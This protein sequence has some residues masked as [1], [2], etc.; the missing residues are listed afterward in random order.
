ML[1][2]ESVL[3][4]QPPTWTGTHSITKSW[5]I[6]TASPS[7]KNNGQI[8]VNRNN[9]FNFEVEETISFILEV[10]DNFGGRDTI[11][12]TVQLQDVN[13]PPV[14][15]T[16]IPP[17]T[18]AE[19]AAVQVALTRYFNDPDRVD[20]GNLRYDVRVEDATIASA[21]VLNG[22]LTINGI[23]AGSTSITVSASDRG[24]FSVSST[25]TVRVNENIPPRIVNPISDQV[26]EPNVPTIIDLNTVFAN[27]NS[28]T[29]ATPQS[30]RSEVAV[31]TLVGANSNRL[32]I[33]GRSA[34]TTTIT[35]TATS[36]SGATITHSF[37]V[38]VNSTPRV[39]APIPNQVVN[40][41]AST[42][43]NLATVFSDPD[44][45]DRL[46]YLR[47]VVDS[48]IVHVSLTG[49]TLRITGLRSGAT[50]VSVVATDNHG[51][52]VT[53][54]FTVRV[55]SAPSVV[56]AIQPA[57]LANPEATHVVEL[58]NVFSDPDPNDV[59][60]YTATSSNAA[61]A[62]V[63]VT[64]NILLVRAVRPGA[65]SIAVTA[66]DSHGESASTTFNFFVNAVPMLSMA[67][68]DILLP[69]P[70]STVQLT[71]TDHFEDA[72][73]EI[74]TFSAVSDDR[75]VVTVS[76][77]GSTLTVQGVMA[78]SATIS[79][80]ATDNHEQT[81]T[82]TFMVH[83]NAI[84]MVSMAIDDVTLANPDAQMDI[85]L[86]MHFSDADMDSLTYMAESSD[87]NTV[88]VSVSGSTLT[89]QG[90]NAGDATVTVTATDTSDASVLDYVRC[91][92]Q[93]CTYGIHGNRRCDSRQS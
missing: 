33:V 55:N 75:S 56:S 86:S 87:T 93:C 6:R 11:N 30:S 70:T 43:I 78:G 28:L 73:R 2:Q 36:E 34:G 74:L 25:F 53:D 76:V 64:G 92:R 79:V 84:P 4:I 23:T 46:T 81:V 22:I 77:S 88:T 40:T 35:L 31:A 67:F 54:S 52:S 51:A 8:Y 3:H 80:S 20:S 42:S 12:I 65:G 15:V 38:T 45:A 85:D 21:S 9:A 32:V 13:E 68:E 39:I 89:V 5:G 44:P 57:T 37:Q 66:T 26:V 41:G 14:K 10:S 69:L 60:T 48:S 24:S 49:A 27:F 7:S 18:V 90:E 16:D 1:K 82:E 47:S 71:L 91:T 83:V 58:T 72:D 50:L 62:T 59:L 17:Q 61:S 19:R 63:S 29:L